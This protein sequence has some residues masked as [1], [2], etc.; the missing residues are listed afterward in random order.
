M[1]SVAHSVGNVLVGRIRILQ[2][3]VQGTLLQ[4]APALLISGTGTT[5]LSA[6]IVES[7]AGGVHANGVFG[8]LHLPSMWL[9]EF[10]LIRLSVSLLTS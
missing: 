5:T 10:E 7:S 4:A 9:N 3:V 8:L 2:L 6:C 1:V